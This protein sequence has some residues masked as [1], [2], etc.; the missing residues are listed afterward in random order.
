MFGD[1]W[2]IA[3]PVLGLIGLGLAYF[4]FT[5]VMKKPQGT[6]LMKEL[7]N[8]IHDGAMV[9]LK[10]EYR[11]IGIFMAVV[12]VILLFGLRREGQFVNWQSAIAYLCGAGLSMLA[13][14]IGM[15]AATRSNARTAAAADKHGVSA[16]LEV[17][18]FGGS[19]MGITVASLGMIGL[20][21]FFYM[22]W[23]QYPDVVSGFA[24][25]ASSVALFAR[26][27]GGIYTKA[28]DVG[29]DLVGKVEAGIPEDDPRN[30]GV[31]ADNVGD[32]VGD[33]AGMGADLFES[34]VG[35][36]VAAIA[37]A[38]TALG[39][40]EAIEALGADK[41]QSMKATLMAMPL[42]LAAVGFVASVLAIFLLKVLKK[43]DP[44][45]VLNYMMILSAVFFV[46]GAFVIV[47]LATA[48]WTKEDVLVLG[49]KA[50]PYGLFYAVVTGIV[51][52]V[53]IGQFTEY[54]TA[55]KPVRRVAEASK[56]GAATNI[57]TGLAVGM[58]SVALP[59]AT[60]AIGVLMAFWCAGLYGIAMAAV[61]MLGTVAMTMSV[62]SYGP[63]ADNAGG[64]TEMAKLGAE[65]RKITDGLDSLGN[66]TAAIGKGFAIGSAAMTALALFGAYT[67]TVV[68]DI[69]SWQAAGYLPDYV[70]DLSL[71]NAKVVVGFFLGGLMPFMLAAMTM[72]A[73][74]KAAMSMV[75]EIR[76]QFREIEGLMEGKAKPDAAR[77]VDIST[78]AAL[79]QMIVPG[80]SAVVAPIIVGVL[81][82]P[83]AL[84]GFLA[85]ATL[86]GVALGLMMA[87]GG[88]AWD[89]AKK[90]IE[91]G[92]LGGKGSDAHKAA[93]VGD[94]VG[95]PF[96]DTSGPS[97]NILIKLMS[98]VSLVLAPLIVYLY[99][100]IYQ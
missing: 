41:A 12:F 33:I 56:T 76:R 52:G 35:S 2:L 92:N 49:W 23:Q 93:V 82:G 10:R 54:Y 63:I 61:G 79:R 68:P 29:A 21:F 75:E 67:S 24:M 22:F 66:T 87:N 90:W 4:F 40:A 30:P 25:G 59:V 7:S 6:D 81:I 53:L 80:V 96:K 60:I 20:G 18:F 44:A 91:E 28:A 58:E 43:M 77:C 94:T 72:T 69:K 42:I 34:F 36:M 99:V 13:G 48:G 55:H 84:G 97:M 37:I 45:K 89:N 3:V 70:F 26:V 39:A 5:L 50:G 46:V 27:G 1:I 14:F 64:I 17:A 51:A 9:F 85:G 71:I 31:I 19:V 11:V 98:V 57:I 86:C 100:W 65:T 15:E 78:T 16:A 95:D 32:N 47:H 8:T 74:G 88:G 73:V 83:E 62:D 38:V